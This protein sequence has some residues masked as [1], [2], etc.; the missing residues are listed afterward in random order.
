MLRHIRRILIA[1]A[2]TPVVLAPRTTLDAVSGVRHL[3]AEPEIETPVFEPLGQPATACLVNSPPSVPL[4]IRRGGLL[5]IYGEGIANVRT[6]TKWIPQ[7]LLWRLPYQRLVSTTPFS[8]LVAPPQADQLFACIVL[9][10]QVDWAVL[11][12]ALVSVYTGNS[13]FTQN[14]PTPKL[15]RHWGAYTHISGRGQVGLAGFGTVYRINVG[16]GEKMTINRGNLLGVTVLGPEDLA[17]CVKG[18]TIEEDHIDGTQATMVVKV[19][20]PKTGLKAYIP[21]LPPI[22]PAVTRAWQW[23]TRQTSSAADHALLWLAG[24]ENFVEVYG[25]RT[26]LVQLGNRLSQPKLNFSRGTEAQPIA[27]PPVIAREPRDY[28]NVVTVK[29]TGVDIELKDSFADEA[30]RIGHKAHK[31]ST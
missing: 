11:S 21:D 5:G 16:D 27:L 2:P 22:P 20:P 1:Q 25:P 15:W 19:A 10:G 3:V 26:L 30:A 4:Y 28:L 8:V 23:I 29:P 6:K 14:K 9:D 31:T 18:F 17:L 12:P 24:T 13:L 7:G